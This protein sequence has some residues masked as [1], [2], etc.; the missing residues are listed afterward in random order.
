MLLMCV[1]RTA[2]AQVIGF[3]SMENGLFFSAVVSTYGMPLIVELGVAF[4]V[5]VAAIL[6][7]VFFFHLRDSFDSLDVVRFNRLSE[8]DEPAAAQEAPAR[9]PRGTTHDA[10][11][12]HAAGAARGQPAA[13]LHRPPPARRLDQ[14][15]HLRGDLRRIPRHGARRVRQRAAAFRGPHVLHRRLQRLP[16]RPHRLRRH[17]LRD[18]L[19]PLHAPRGRA[20]PR[21]ATGGCACT[22][23]CTRASCSRCCWRSRPTTSASCG[24]RWRRPPSRP[25]C[26]SRSIARRRRS[27]RRGSTSSSA[28]S[29]SP[30]RSSA[31]CSSTSPPRTGS[32]CERDDALLWTV[33]HGSAAANLDPAVISLAF[34]F[35][36]V[37]YGTKVGLVPLH[38]W[39]PDAHSEGPDADVR[40]ALR[41]AAQRG[42]LRPG[43]RQ[44]AGRR[45]AAHEPRRPPDDGLRPAVVHG[46][47][48]VP[49]P[50]ARREAHVQLFVHRA[51]GAHDFR[52]R[53]RRPARHVRGAAAH[54]GALAHQVGDLRHR[55]PRLRSSPA[56]SAS[57]RS[58][59][60]S[61]RSPRSAGR[62]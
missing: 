39:L 21:H 32:A 60:S 26:W 14:R 8:T 27:R 19:A 22:T 6:F 34:V 44:D 36:L 51:H 54:D 3:M 10:A 12:D 16:R 56:R 52:L 53:H 33:L 49:A 62:C 57:T 4:D 13:R 38:N 5:L 42:A 15:G 1:R 58:A 7:G 45:L 24:S 9:R 48:A 31:R 18:L 41:A 37:G 35:L 17:D 50:P 23:P 11:R 43:A 47:G 59:A 28:A 55:R 20:R 61:A 40:G 25:C 46:G 29:A 30:R 2:V